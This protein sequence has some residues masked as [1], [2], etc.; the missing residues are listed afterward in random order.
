[1]K[2]I[3][4][5]IT[6][7]VLLFSKTL[8]QAHSFNA[9][10]ILSN[11]TAIAVAQQHQLADYKVVDRGVI[12]IYERERPGG[13]LNLF[14]PVVTYYFSLKDSEKIYLLNLENLKNIYRDGKAFDLIDG[15]FRTDNDLFFY[16]P[17]HHQ[18]RINYYLSKINH[19]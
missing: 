13:K 4:F 17:Y 12:I 15:N 7:L 16:D 9:N 2:T 8:V 5:S 3:T 18:Y 10:K 6:L 11:N 1:M 14:K 19:S